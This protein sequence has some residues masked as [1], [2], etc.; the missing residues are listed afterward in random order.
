MTGSLENTLYDTYGVILPIELHGNR[1]LVGRIY[2]RVNKVVPRNE[3]TAVFSDKAGVISRGGGEWNVIQADTKDGFELI[4]PVTYYRIDF[5]QKTAG[6]VP[7]FAVM[8]GGHVTVG[9][10]WDIF[11]GTPWLRL[12]DISTIST[13]KNKIRFTRC[14]SDPKYLE[15]V[16]F[17]VNLNYSQSLKPD[18][19]NGPLPYPRI[20]YDFKG[21]KL[22]TQYSELPYDTLTGDLF[23]GNGGQQI[24][25]IGAQANQTV[26]SVFLNID[27]TTTEYIISVTSGDSTMGTYL[28]TPRAIEDPGFVSHP[29][30]HD[31][32]E[33][34]QKLSEIVLPLYA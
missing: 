25:I 19:S 17:G 7:E 10:Q 22:R 5:V 13:L 31:Y 14:D 21:S 34:V 1:E 6:M 16:T 29:T 30:L 3:F 32:D 20:S 9:F 18:N 11:R 23:V 12:L 26:P 8:K 33:W 24:R 15:P 2:E 27:S 28:R 4:P